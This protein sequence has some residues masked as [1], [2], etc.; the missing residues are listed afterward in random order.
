MKQAARFPCRTLLP[1]I[2]GAIGITY[3]CREPRAMS[4]GPRSSFTCG[5]SSIA[6]RRPG[7]ASQTT[8]EHSSSVF[9]SSTLKGDEQFSQHVAKPPRNVKTYRGSH[10]KQR[11]RFTSTELKRGIKITK[12]QPL[13]QEA[14]LSRFN[15]SEETLSNLNF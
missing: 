15:P 8:P 4:I 3:T 5:L 13:I 7:Q 11:Q 1:K 12:P 10:A 6:L 2:L 9:I 14:R